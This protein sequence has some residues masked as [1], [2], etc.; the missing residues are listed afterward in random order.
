[1]KIAIIG[2]G[3][4]GTANAM[5][6]DGYGHEVVVWC[7]RAEAAR[8]F[9]ETRENR[10]YLP[11]VRLPARLTFTADCA[12]AVAGADVV[13][14]AV[15]S[16]HLR[17]I[18]R[19]FRGL[20]PADACRVSLVKGIEAG[21]RLRMSEVI[22]GELGDAPLVVLSGPSHAEEVARHVPTALVAASAD[23][24]SARL[25]QAL[26]SGPALRVYTSRD[27]I[28]VE[29]AGA[30]KNVLA[31]A[32]GCSDGLGFGD[33]TRAA[34]VTRGLAEMGRLATACGA[35]AAT[36]SGLAGVGDLVVTCNSRHSRNHAVGERLGRGERMAD[37]LA[38]MT[39]VAEGVD[40]ARSIHELAQTLGVEMPIAEIVN[41]ICHADYPVRDAIVALMTRTMKDE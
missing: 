20:L 40:N 8:E 38:S 21:T 23:I 10:R 35:A 22:A 12:Q 14:F 39:M 34:L 32:A 5:V 29:V 13:V 28:G 37:I 16:A 30:V 7:R 3:G 15:P 41:R 25:V 6:L 19:R 36:I 1:M 11:G 26:W 24:R 4:W 31:L 33:N 27:P 17:T 2:A 18:C 9:A